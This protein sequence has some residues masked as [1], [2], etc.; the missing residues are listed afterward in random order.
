MLPRH[1][2]ERQAGL[3]SGG[4]VDLPGSLGVRGSKSP[5]ELQVWWP[6]GTPNRREYWT[7]GF[8]CYHGPLFLVLLGTPTVCVTVWATLRVYFDNI[9]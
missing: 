2:P 1:S 7:F 9:G 8:S 4:D 5:Q 3:R 6:L